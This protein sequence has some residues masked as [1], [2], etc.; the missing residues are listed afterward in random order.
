MAKMLN[1]FVQLELT[2]QKPIKNAEG[3][4]I[5]EEAVEEYATVILSDCK[6]VKKGDIVYFMSFS[7]YRSKDE[8]GKE[9][10]F[11]ESNKIM[12]CK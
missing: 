11:I 10:A 8:K 7:V 5:N 2:K 4:V 6:A 9:I 3:K 12:K 1:G